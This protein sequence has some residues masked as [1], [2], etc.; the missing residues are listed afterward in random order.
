MIS[1]SKIITL[2]NG[3]PCLVIADAQDEQFV[4]HAKVL[5]DACKGT[6]DNIFHTW[7][8]E[9]SMSTDGAV[10]RTLTKLDPIPHIKAQL[11]LTHLD[12]QQDG[13]NTG[14][15][16]TIGLTLVLSPGVADPPPTRIRWTCYISDNPKS[17]LAPETQCQLLEAQERELLASG[18]PVHETLG[19]AIDDSIAG[20]SSAS[21]PSRSNLSDVHGRSSVLTRSAFQSAPEG[22]Q[23]ATEHSAEIGPAGTGNTGSKGDSSRWPSL[24]SKLRK[25]KGKRA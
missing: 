24:L 8:D 10:D 5:R 14:L 17:V 18:T 11:F 9:I 23:S 1:I 19:L 25:G 20:K 6:V 12:D 3:L 2:E 22:P 16:G 21:G 15:K 13:S 4:T 7:I